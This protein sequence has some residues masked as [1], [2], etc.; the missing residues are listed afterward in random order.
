[1]ARSSTGPRRIHLDLDAIRSATDPS[2]RKKSARIRRAH[3]RDYG[4]AIAS[5]RRDHGLKQSEVDGISE[6]Q[7]R[8]IEQTGDVSVSVLEKLAKAHRM[9]LARYL[10]EI[11]GNPDSPR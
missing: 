8:R 4:R 2:W 11:A 6:R 9:P 7:L 5:M 1:M 10:D 3:G